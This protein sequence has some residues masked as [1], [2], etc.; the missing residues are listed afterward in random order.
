MKRGRPRKRKIDSRAKT[1]LAANY[2][3]YDF[4]IFDHWIELMRHYNAYIRIPEDHKA[5]KLVMKKHWYN[6]YTSSKK[7][8]ESTKNSKNP[9]PKPD[10][11][12]NKRKYILNYDDLND[13]VSVHGGFTFA[14]LIKQKDLKD[15]KQGFT[16]GLWVGWDYAHAGDEIYIE[17]EEDVLP[18][19]RESWRSIMA[20]HNNYPRTNEKR[21]TLEEVG[22]HTLS[23][24][25]DLRIMVSWRLQIVSAIKI[26][27]K[28]CVR[29]VVRF[30]YTNL[31]P[32]KIM[33]GGEK[34][35]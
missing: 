4:V 10:K 30:W 11:S 18:E 31:F 26:I 9:F 21:W 32:R 7:L 25:D 12:L 3:G 14:R 13:F 29:Y 6:F 27:W 16:P 2:K 34:I 28:I 22:K 24:I 8:S 1:V 33:E 19:N 20:I 17:K 23:A 15:W 5:Y 35:K